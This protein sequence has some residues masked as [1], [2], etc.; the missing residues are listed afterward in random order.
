MS[1]SRVRPLL[2]QVRLSRGEKAALRAVADAR[3]LTEAEVIRAA[4]RAAHAELA[5]RGAEAR[6]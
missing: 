3:E 6:A 1:R 5:A 2:L 4:I